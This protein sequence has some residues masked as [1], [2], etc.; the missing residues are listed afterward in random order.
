MNGL[1]ADQGEPVVLMLLPAF[2]G[3]ASCGQPAVDQ[4]GAERELT[5]RG[6]S[7]APVALGISWPQIAAVW[8]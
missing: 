4:V 2:E 5:P 1:P 3:Q 8:E 6:A 7:L